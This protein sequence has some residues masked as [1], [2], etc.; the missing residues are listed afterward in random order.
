MYNKIKSSSN[1]FT[2]FLLLIT[3]A[4]VFYSIASNWSQLRNATMFDNPDLVG[5]PYVVHSLLYEHDKF[6]NW[7]LTNAFFLFPDIVL[8]YIISF[9][10]QNIYHVFPLFA[11]IQVSL[12][13]FLTSILFKVATKSKAGLRLGLVSSLLFLLLLIKIHQFYLYSSYDYI[14]TIIVPSFHFGSFIIAILCTYLFIKIMQNSKTYLLILL[15]FLVIITGIS[16]PLLNYYFTFPAIAIIFFAYLFNY[17]NIKKFIN[18]LCWFIS[19]L[20]AWYVIYRYLPLPFAKINFQLSFP[21]FHLDILGNTIKKFILVARINIPVSFLWLLFILLAPISLIRSYKQ[22]NIRIIDYLILFELVVIFCGFIGLLTTN[23]KFDLGQSSIPI[24][25]MIPLITGP[26]FLGL[27]L[28]IYKNF[29]FVKKLGKNG[30][31]AFTLL[32]I[33]LLALH[34]KPH[35]IKQNFFSY[36]PKMIACFDKYAKKLQL[37]NGIADDWGIQNTYNAYNKSE[38]HIVLVPDLRTMQPFLWFSTSGLYRYHHFDFVMLDTDSRLEKNKKAMYQKF[39]KPTN[40]FVCPI[41]D[42]KK[43]HVYVYKN[44]VMKNVSFLKYLN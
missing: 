43:Q 31:F 35:F 7:R 24:R 27:P 33:S 41:N 21:L 2:W 29:V 30:V 44:G 26:A 23:V 13:I 32:V 15:S 9:F 12:F 39:G 19:M 37:H 10:T 16:D 11:F 6:Y 5:D 20:V 4:L 8:I 38:A 14:V 3:L 40:Q 25:Y 42:I 18:Y 34:H 22:N 36:Y 28:V 1:L 17:I